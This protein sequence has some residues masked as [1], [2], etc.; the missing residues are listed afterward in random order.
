[1]IADREIDK[2][3]TQLHKSGIPF[4]LERV[5]DGV[6]IGYP[7]LFQGCVCS[8]I[9]NRYSYGYKDGLLEIRGLLTPD[10]EQADTVAGWLTAN[11]VFTRIKNHWENQISLKTVWGGKFVQ[12][13]TNFV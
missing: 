3:L 12:Y 6:H 10:E 1:M 4:E 11:D 7:C 5:F 2:L 8:V 13:K 9:Y